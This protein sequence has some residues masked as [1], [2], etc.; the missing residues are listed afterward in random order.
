MP[1]KQSEEGKHKIAT[2]FLTK[3]IS[4]CRLEETQKACS[5]PYGLSS[6][7]RAGCS[8]LSPELL[9][10]ML[11]SCIL[12][13]SRGQHTAGQWNKKPSL[14]CSKK[15]AEPCY[16]ERYTAWL[17]CC[18]KKAVYEKAV[19]CA[20][21]LPPSHCPAAEVR[22]KWSLGLPHAVSYW[23]CSCAAQQLLAALSD[24]L[25]WIWFLNNACTHCSDTNASFSIFCFFLFAEVIHTVVMSCYAYALS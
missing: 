13:W 16:T 25:T 22:S 5:V 1:T 18:G 11:C 23:G 17:G 10:K 12:C 2:P 21:L 3:I 20:S 4:S 7:S 9:G 24:S 15:T 14:G 19:L 8:S 6:G